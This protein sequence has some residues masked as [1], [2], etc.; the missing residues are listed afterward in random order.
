MFG[1]ANRLALG[2]LMFHHSQLFY[3]PAAFIRNVYHAKPYSSDLIKNISHWPKKCIKGKFWRYSIPLWAT[4]YILVLQDIGRTILVHI[5]PLPWWG[6]HPM[7]KSVLDHFQAGLHH[8]T[9]YVGT[10]DFISLVCAGT[11]NLK[12]TRQPSHALSAFLAPGDW[13]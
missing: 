3:A 4:P 12:S 13:A 8:F 9:N 6:G 2:L 1:Y 11:K 10:K 7:N 5:W